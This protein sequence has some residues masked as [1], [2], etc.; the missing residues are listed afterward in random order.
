MASLFELDVG[1]LAT[2]ARVEVRVRLVTVDRPLVPQS[3]TVGLTWAFAIDGGFHRKNSVLVEAC[4]AGHAFLSESEQLHLS[5]LGNGSFFLAALSLAEVI[6]IIFRK[7]RPLWLV[8][9]GL[10]GFRLQTR[11][12]WIS[13]LNHKV[14]LVRLEHLQ[15]VDRGVLQDQWWLQNGP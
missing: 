1:F 4:I 12:I 10:R 14:D 11:G 7:P 13:L 3:L 9:G 8:D 15:L 6:L 5:F 2:Y